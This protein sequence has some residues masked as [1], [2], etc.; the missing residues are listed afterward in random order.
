MHNARTNI[1]CDIPALRYVKTKRFRLHQL[2][3]IVASSCNLKTLRRFT[4]I[5]FILVIDSTTMQLCSNCECSRSEYSCLDCPVLE[6]N[7]C[8]S[9]CDLHTKVKSTKDHRL[10]LSGPKLQIASETKDMA[11]SHAHTED[12]LDVKLCSFDSCSSKSVCPCK[13]FSSA[14]VISKIGLIIDKVYDI[15]TAL[16]DTTDFFALLAFFE[17]DTVLD[18]FPLTY[19][20][21][22]IICLLALAMMVSSEVITNNGSSIAMIIGAIAFLQ[23]SRWRNG[24]MQFGNEKICNSGPIHPNRRKNSLCVTSARPFDGIQNS[25]LPTHRNLH[26]HNY[27]KKV[28]FMILQIVFHNSNLIFYPHLL[29][30]VVVYF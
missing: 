15:C 25:N 21:I 18:K 3:A 23:R 12:I 11:I 17:I 9:C 5:V 1:G 27:R 28:G 19:A 6:R 30:H 14:D 8:I 24:S 7:F 10:I 2:N 26:A 20:L 29:L 4:T 16:V 22:P 13:N